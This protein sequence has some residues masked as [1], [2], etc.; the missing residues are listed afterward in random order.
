[1]ESSYSKTIWAFVSGIAI[2][3]FDKETNV[4]GLGDFISSRYNEGKYQN[5]HHT[6]LILSS[7][8]SSDIP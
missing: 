4:F 3:C 6:L 5:N 7:F 8:T 2:V 1:L